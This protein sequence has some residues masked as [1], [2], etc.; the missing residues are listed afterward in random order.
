MRA[1]SYIIYI[2]VYRI[3]RFYTTKIASVGSS[4]ALISRFLDEN[5]ISFQLIDCFSLL[6]MLCFAINT[7]PV[8]SFLSV[9][10]SH[11]TNPLLL[12]SQLVISIPYYCEQKDEDAYL[13]HF[14][15]VQLRLLTSIFCFS[16][17]LFVYMHRINTIS[18]STL[19]LSRP[20]NIFTTAEYS[21][22]TDSTTN[23]SPPK[24]KRLLLFERFQE[25]AAG[26]IAGTIAI[27]GTITDIHNQW[28][29]NE[30]LV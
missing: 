11:K 5:N 21:A 28:I 13:H 7:F 26:T 25:L 29:C 14:F 6:L 4:F 18:T 24:P 16:R 22:W 19:I 15:P 3:Q 8:L 23:M 2:F 1:P 10:C 17:V 9:P 27:A 30:E 20:P 12:K